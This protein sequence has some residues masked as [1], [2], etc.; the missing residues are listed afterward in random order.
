M[1]EIKYAITDNDIAT[2]WEAMLLLRPM[3]KENAFVA[4][5]KDLPK[6]EVL[7]YIF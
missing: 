7:G 2:C 3:L 5:I 1:A 6:E 4:Q